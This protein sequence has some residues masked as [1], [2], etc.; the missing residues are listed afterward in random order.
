VRAIGPAATIYEQ[1]INADS[2]SFWLKNSSAPTTS[3]VTINYANTTAIGGGGM[4][5][6]APAGL[7]PVLHNNLDGTTANCTG[8]LGLFSITQDSTMGF[9][10]TGF[11]GPMDIFTCD[12]SIPIGSLAPAAGD[13]SY[14]SFQAVTD[15]VG[16]TLPALGE[17]DFPLSVVNN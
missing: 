5:L 9:L 16:N 17:G 13:F 1:T 8:A 12:Y 7:V 10:S 15:P 11:V 6:V 3:T 14:N 4:T 2:S